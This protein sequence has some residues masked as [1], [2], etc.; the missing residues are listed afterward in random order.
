MKTIAFVA[1]HP[2]DETIGCG[3]TILKYINK[4]YK[5]HWIIATKPKKNLKSLK[6]YSNEIER[7]KKF[8][9]FFKVHKLNLPST[10]LDKVPKNKI[11][12]K[13]KDIFSKISVNYAFI[14]YEHDAHSD[15]KIINES[16]LA[17]LKWFRQ[18]SIE[19]ILTYEVLSE[20]NFNFKDKNNI[21]FKPNLYIDITKTIKD[22]INVIKI[23]KS[24]FSSH[25]FPRN[26]KAIKSQ[27]IIRGSESGFKYAEA[28]KILYEREG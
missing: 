16:C 18:K 2:D 7:V 27:G 19:K 15:H 28:F 13:F 20:T 12:K 26:I 5:V 8:Y 14:P 3:G 17:S 24:E 1:P 23:Y 25:P 10:Y 22:K 21:I 11:I 6:L 4:N 9:K